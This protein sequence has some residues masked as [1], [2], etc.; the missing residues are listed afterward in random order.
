MIQSHSKSAIVS[1]NIHSFKCN[2]HL[3]LPKGQL[4]TATVY[5]RVDI[6]TLYSNSQKNKMSRVTTSNL[7]RDVT[8]TFVHYLINCRQFPEIIGDLSKRV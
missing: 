1:A 7:H 8:L 4:E 5:L 2:T 6:C 3:L